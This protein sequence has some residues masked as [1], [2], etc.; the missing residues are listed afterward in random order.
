MLEIITFVSGALVMV[1]EMVGARVMAPHLGTSVI[2]WTSLIGVILACLAIGAWL[3]GRIADKTL[4]YGILAT[5]IAGAGVGCSLT[6]LL[7]FKVGELIVNNIG[8]IYEG[9]VVAAIS[10]FA[11]PA[12]LFGMVSPYVIRLRLADIKTAGTTVGRLYALSTTGSIIGTFL[13]GFVL[14]SWFK[15]THILLGTGIAMVALSFLAYRA[16]PIIRIILIIIFPALFFINNFSSGKTI[17]E[18]ALPHIESPYNHIIIEQYLTPENRLVRH[19]STDPGGAQSGMYLDDPS[20][21]L[22]SYTRFYAI[23]TAVVPHA[24]NILMLGC[25]GYSLVKWLLSGKAGLAASSL[26]IDAVEIDPAMTR[27]A[28]EYFALPE[29]DP[30]I[31]IYHEDARRFCNTNAKQYDLV[32][33]DAFNS[34]YSI[35]FHMATMEAIS[36]MRRSVAVNGALVMNVISSIEGEGSGLYKAVMAGLNAAFAEVYA[37]AVINPL[38]SSTLQ[39]IVLLALPESRP[40]L[41]PIFSGE[42]QTVKNLASDI[43]HFLSKRIKESSIEGVQPFYDEYAPVEKHAQAMIKLI[44]K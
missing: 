17:A 43:Q 34:Y 26:K 25:G 7:H 40:D 9:A 44:K 27:S 41:A 31:S 29:N 36:A 15:S 14:V 37:F 13:G 22:F 5:I 4:S 16:K 23:G 2:V 20:D 12:V 42:E 33:V 19:M 10:L 30:R 21:L 32:F 35:P 28:I 39:N 38:Y 1:L 18:G 24:E 8:G 6:A 3:G 11:L